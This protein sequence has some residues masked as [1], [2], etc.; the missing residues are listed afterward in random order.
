MNSKKQ[1][2][3]LFKEMLLI[4][5]VEEEISKRYSGQK[6]RCP[7][8]LSIGQEAAAVGFCQALKK[9]DKIFSTHRCHSHYLAKGGNLNK[10]IS[11]IYGK[12]NG[13]AQG[14][15]GS[16]HLFDI[17]AGILSSV[18]IVGS[19][20]PLATGSALSSKIDGEKDVTAVFFG[21]ATVEEGVFH[22]SMNFASLYNLPVIFICE[23]NL[24]SC[25]TKLEERQP[26]RPISK[27]GQAHKV[28]TFIT[29]GND[30]DKVFRYSN[31]AIS[32]SR[33]NSKP[34]FIILNTYRY[35]EHC[36]PSNDNN[37]KYRS[38]K[39]YNYWINR[40]PITTYKKKLLNKKIISF[41]EVNKIETYLQK[42]IENAFKFAINSKLPDKSLSKKYI[43]A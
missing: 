2:L 7:I 11:E 36:G 27:L 15:G 8:H 1:S 14:R 43:Y 33:S 13:C 37:L 4:R 9:K 38:L 29:D 12:V 5:L 18:P 34:A 41:D 17:D 42:R 10:M 6:M 28:K 22:E 19:S 40:D 30:V 24:Y 23:N 21:D 26:K 3:L 25:Y 20:I 16:M 39:E 31:D 32:Y 35:L